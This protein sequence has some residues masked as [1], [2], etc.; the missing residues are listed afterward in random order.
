MNYTS[1]A[2]DRSDIA[3]FMLTRVFD[4]RRMSTRNNTARVTEIVG[5]GFEGE[6]GG[7]FDLAFFLTGRPHGE[8]I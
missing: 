8:F 7:P 3:S 4:P 6:E 2:G 5:Q 1:E